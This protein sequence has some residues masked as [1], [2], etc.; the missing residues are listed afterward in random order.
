VDSGDPLGNVLAKVGIQV[1]G[2]T[3]SRLQEGNK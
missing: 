2:F 1:V 3:L